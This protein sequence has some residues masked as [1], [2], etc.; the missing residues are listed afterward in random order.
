MPHIIEMK[1][2]HCSSILLAHG[3][4]GGKSSMRQTTV[5]MKGGIILI[6]QNTLSLSSDQNAKIN[7][8]LSKHN[9]AHS[10]Q[11]DSV[12]T[13]RYNKFAH[14]TLSNLPQD[15]NENAYTF[16]SPEVLL[17]SPWY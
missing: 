17:K 12:K 8:V 2:N 9:G 16:S 6:V 10:T 1:N 13:P 5:I 3:T 7:F 4:G 11:L 15:T 14:S